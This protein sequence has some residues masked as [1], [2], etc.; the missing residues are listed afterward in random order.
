[1][2]FRSPFI[3]HNLNLSQCDVDEEA[4]ALDAAS[5]NEDGESHTARVS[6]CSDSRRIHKVSK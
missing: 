3:A 6:E 1:M 2:N 5:D 4:E